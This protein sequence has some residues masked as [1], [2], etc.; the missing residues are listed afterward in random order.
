MI[1][2]VSSKDLSIQT[3]TADAQR[4]IDEKLC[5]DKYAR[6]DSPVSPIV[7]LSAADSLFN[8][9]R[10]TLHISRLFAHTTVES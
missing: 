10:I 5:A 9:S 6:G 2:F 1:E 4:S 7:A 8:K 3:E